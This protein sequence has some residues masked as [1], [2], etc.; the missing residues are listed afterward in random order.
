M[1][2]WHHRNLAMYLI[3]H[4]TQIFVRQDYEAMSRYLDT[5]L[6]CD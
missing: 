5:S 6:A 1:G 4:R 2:S 3:A